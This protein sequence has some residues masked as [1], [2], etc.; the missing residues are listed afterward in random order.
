MITLTTANDIQAAYDKTT[1]HEGA[2]ATCRL[3]EG[4]WEQEN[5]QEWAEYCKIDGVP[6][7]VYYMFDNDE[8]AVEDGADMPW[9][10]EHV[11]KIEIAEIEEGEEYEKI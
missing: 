9:D 10:F 3:L 6:A 2:F 4:E 7:K 1:D 5:R 11:T 8:A